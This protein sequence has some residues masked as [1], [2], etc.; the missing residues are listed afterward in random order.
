MNKTYT[1]DC[2][3]CGHHQEVTEVEAYKTGGHTKCNKCGETVTVYVTFHPVTS[4][5]L[6]RKGW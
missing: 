1:Y 5:T 4:N 2:E 3:H 6:V